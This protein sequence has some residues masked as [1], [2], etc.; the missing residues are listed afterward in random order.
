M[1][2]WSS[3]LWL[4][5]LAAVPLLWWM[6]RFRRRGAS[7]TVSAL[8]LWPG[9]ERVAESRGQ[10]AQADPWWRLRALLAAL[11]AL[12]MAGPH[13]PGETAPPLEIWFDDSPSLQT[14][15]DGTT[16]RQLALAALDEALARRDEGEV[17]VRSLAD[18]ARQ[19]RLPPGQR[20][21]WPA[22]LDDW[23]QTDS[24]AATLPPARQMSPRHEHWLV[25]DGA[26]PALAGWLRTAPV[27]RVIQVGR[28]TENVA[29]RRLALRPDSE[30]A[31][32][33]RG[34]VTVENLGQSVA[35]RRLSIDSDGRTLASFAVELAAGEQHR[36]AFVLDTIPAGPVRARLDPA[37]ALPRDDLLVLDPQPLA[38]VPSRIDAAC[39]SHLR[40]AI[41]AHPG[42]RVV[43]GN[44]AAEL[45][46]ACG[47][48]PPRTALP[49]IWLH[50]AGAASA[51]AGE[52]VWQAG[53]GPLRRL[54]LQPDW[55]RRFTPA[56]APA[57]HVL[58]RAGGQPLVVHRAQPSPRMEVLLDMEYPPWARRPEQP[59]LFAA[60]VDRLLDRPVLDAVASAARPREASL[61]AP[62]P[63]QARD[64][65]PV[66]A[67]AAGSGEDLGPYLIL[68][69]ALLL[70]LDLRRRLRAD[71]RGTK[72]A[73][74]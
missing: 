11:L 39:G 1:P 45:H 61:I 54:V 50:T 46:I 33:I 51:V 3:P 22:R 60:L 49:A 2:E 59:L 56:Q 65:T 38:P 14:R 15:E 25:S 8:F 13:W 30:Q 26:D 47:A 7:L 10:P 36:Y 20:G 34:L 57:G 70:A 23:L 12:G 17:R 58:L 52:P 74:A 43:S 48:E 24:G 66:A 5:A 69:A 29:L 35:S 40:A 68:A 63:L 19:L 73:P 67:R 28:E 16:R 71:R 72:G 27:R 4:G 53:T 32:R 21:T 44:G 62:R 9:A 64:V 6:H 55:L 41:E 37:D 18:P 42:L 31:S